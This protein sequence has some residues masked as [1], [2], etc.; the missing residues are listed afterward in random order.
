M[1]SE[2]KRFEGYVAVFYPDKFYGFITQDLPGTSS[3]P[4]IYFGSRDIRPDWKRLHR[5]RLGAPGNAGFSFKSKETE[6]E[7]RGHLDRR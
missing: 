7:V 6:Q 4:G 1:S 3:S 2:Q 5:V